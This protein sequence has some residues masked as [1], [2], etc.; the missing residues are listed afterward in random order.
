MAT[1]T[2]S[3]GTN[4]SIAGIGSAYIQAASTTS[5]STATNSL[6]ANAFLKMFLT[7]LQN[8]DPTNPMQSYELA[9][10]LAQFT[11]VQQ[12]SQVTTQLN[13]IQQ[14]SA[15]MNNGDIASLVGKK[16]TAQMSGITV[17]SGTPTSL[18]YTL[19]SPATVSY[20][21]A[22]SNGNK[23][24]T[25][26]IGSQS[27]GTYTIPWNGKESNGTTAPDGA[28]TCTVTATAT[29]GTTSTVKTTVQGLVYSCDLTANPPTYLLTGPGGT[30][31]P[32][33]SVSAV[34]SS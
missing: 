27:A 16:V 15:D 26:S 1:T 14:Y 12:L 18:S 9:S 21:I 28:Y 2:S 29:D 30:K 17:T 3:T 8:Q 23:V 31:V 7:Q 22:D 11:S 6:D 34:S 24:Y 4:Q 19:S 33:S 5:S 10:Q 25:G 32:V 13:D 20:T